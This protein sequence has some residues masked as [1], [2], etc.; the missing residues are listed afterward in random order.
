MSAINISYRKFAAKT[1]RHISSLS[2]INLKTVFNLVNKHNI[3]R[4]GHS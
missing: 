1:V 2:L 3:G 4:K